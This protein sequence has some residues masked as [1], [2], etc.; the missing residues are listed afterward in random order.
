MPLEE[1]VAKR[2]TLNALSPGPRNLGEN[3]E[4][5]KQ[6]LLV[7]GGDMSNTL[8]EEALKFGAITIYHLGVLGRGNAGD[9]LA[10]WHVQHRRPLLKSLAGALR[11]HQTVCH[12]ME[13]LHSRSAA[14]VARVRVVHE[15]SPFLRGMLKT[16]GA[17]LVG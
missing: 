5:L 9:I 7:H 2:R 1:E 8:A 10:E 13:D 14:G 12:T 4:E 15:V 11:T 17:S 3:T 6:Q 16:L